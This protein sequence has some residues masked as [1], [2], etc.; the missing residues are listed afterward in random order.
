MYLS[1]SHEDKVPAQLTVRNFVLLGTSRTKSQL[2]MSGSHGC[3]VV[4][5]HEPFFGGCCGCV[6]R[7]LRMLFFEEGQIRNTE[8]RTQ[9]SNR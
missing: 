6:D 5:V 1:I 2:G 4:D 7:N 3:E 9:T 8:V